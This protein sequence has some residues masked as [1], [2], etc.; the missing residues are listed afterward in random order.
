MSITIVVD[1]TASF[2]PSLHQEYQDLFIVPLNIHFG[3]EVFREKIDITNEDFYTRLRVDS[4]FP[5][6]SQPSTGDFLL[7]FENAKAGD[8]GIFLTVSSHLSGTY[9]SAAMAAKMLKERAVNVEV[10]DTL[11]VTGS[12]GFLVERACELCLLGYPLADITKE[13]LDLRQ[14]VRLFFVPKTLEYLARGGRIGRLSKVLGNTMQIKPIITMIDG[15]LDPSEKV[16][17]DARAQ[18]RLISKVEEIASQLK[19]LAVV[20]ADNMEEALLFRDK[21]QAYY[22]SPIPIYSVT[23][24]LG[25]H[26][27]PGTL[28]IVYY[29]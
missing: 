22:S 19:R 16:R 26:V 20:E 23:P 8:E 13:L 4:C 9:Q 1:S 27:G 14:R 18:A 7:P 10:I 15:V 17:T 3:D 21:L 28:G 25:A 11:T 6:T 2:R 5:K 29:T 12:A 24:V